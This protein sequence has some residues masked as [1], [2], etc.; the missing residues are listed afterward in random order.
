MS[1]A[2]K[3]FTGFKLSSDSSSLGQGSTQS[4]AAL[5]TGG[6]FGN[7]GS[8]SFAN[9]GPSAFNNQSKNLFESLK[10]PGESTSQE[11]GKSTSPPVNGELQ[12]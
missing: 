8:S 9:I 6:L 10:A 4:D 2:L 1:D 12:S 7:T 11:A 5:K 3:G